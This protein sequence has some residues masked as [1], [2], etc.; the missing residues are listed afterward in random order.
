MKF[1]ILDEQKIC[2]A[3]ASNSIMQKAIDDLFTWL[4]Q[5]KE[6]QFSDKIQVRDT[7]H[8]GRGIFLSDGNN[9]LT[10]NEI[11]ISIPNDYQLDFYTVLH[12]I[13][14]FNPHIAYPPSDE[15]ITAESI[16]KHHRAKMLDPNNPRYKAYEIF[17][18]DKLLNLKSFQLLSLYILAEWIL[19]PQWSQISDTKFASFWEPFFNIWPTRKELSSIP[20]IWLTRMNAIATSDS[21][22]LTQLFNLLPNESKLH[23]E[24]ILKLVQDDW[25]VIRPYLEQW[26]KIF[27][28]QIDLNELFNHFV[29]IYFIINSRCLYCELP[30]KQG[31]DDFIESNFTLVPL[32]DFLN[33]ADEMDK[34][35]YPEVQKDSVHSGVSNGVGQFIMRVGSHQYNKSN[36]QILLNYGPH[37]N[38]FL[39]C[40]Y[41]FVMNQNKWNYI[42]I[43]DYILHLINMQQEKDE[44]VNFLSTNEYL[45]DYTINMDEFSYRTL[46]AISLIVTKDYR[47]VERFIQ[48]YITEEFFIPKIKKTLLEILNQ[49]NSK[50]K[51]KINNLNQLRNQIDS[52]DT[53]VLDTSCTDYKLYIDNLLCIYHGYMV[54]TEKHANEL[55]T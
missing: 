20:T 55:N 28:S 42:D 1:F 6:F 41:G 33:H 25:D 26:D 14:L 36:E 11:I 17:Q 23:S 31:M 2:T 22:I 39:L 37:S 18:L 19:L 54:I 46:V 21:Q 50:Y 8:S 44:L 47:R 32:V 53:K 4:K 16:R 49:L 13:S 40:E 12:H 9:P 48:G 35:C 43:T 7:E 3:I 29:H 5:S 10:T 24:K 45:G 15:E 52:M 30:L 27:H 51:G 38:D 34:F